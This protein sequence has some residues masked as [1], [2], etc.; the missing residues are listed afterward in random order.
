MLTGRACFIVSAGIRIAE[1]LSDLFFCTGC[2][3][4]VSFCLLVLDDAEEHRNHVVSRV[5]IKIAKHDGLRLDSV[6]LARLISSVSP[7]SGDADA[8]INRQSVV[9]GFRGLRA[10]PPS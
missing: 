2:P 6:S 4:N 5:V 10:P 1:A 9:Q 7:Q 3:I 8:L